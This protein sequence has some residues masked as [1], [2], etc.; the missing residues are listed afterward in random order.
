M[1][2][3]NKLRSP[4]DEIGGCE[5][6]ID[7][8][9]RKRIEAAHQFFKAS[10]LLQFLDCAFRVVDQLAAIT[11]LVFQFLAAHRPYRR[12]LAPVA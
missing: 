10:R 5:R 4:L 1:A 6:L 11:N 9:L 2:S 8:V 12:A 7:E 3:R